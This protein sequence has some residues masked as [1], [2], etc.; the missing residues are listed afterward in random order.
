MSLQEY[1]DAEDHALKQSLLQ[2]PEHYRLFGELVDLYDAVIHDRVRTENDIVLALILVL[3]VQ[4]HLLGVG[5]QLLRRRVTGAECLTHRA[6]EATVAAHYSWNHP[7]FKPVSPDRMFKGG[8]PALPCLPTPVLPFGAMP[9]P[10]GPGAAVKY[11]LLHGALKPEFIEPD[12]QTV[13]QAWETHLSAYGELLEVALTFFAATIEDSK[14]AL[15]RV[16]LA[17]WKITVGA[18]VQRVTD[19]PSNS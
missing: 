18:L 16:A 14:V 19:A 15:L 13:R 7:G 11:Q 8:T 9:A 1:L 4:D 12:D 10:A 17:R 3:V 5:S 2:Y 6:I